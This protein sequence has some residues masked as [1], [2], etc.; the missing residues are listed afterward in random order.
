MRVGEGT[1]DRLAAYSALVTQ[2]SPR[3]DLVAPG[4]VVRF[5]QRHIEDCLRLLSLAEGCPPGAAADVGSGAGLPGLVLAIAQPEQLWRL[6][7]P[8]S[9]RAA[10][11]EE[12]VRELDLANVEVL[13]VT[14][15]QGAARA[16]LR[17]GHILA[18]ARALAPPEESLRL[19]RPLLAPGGTAAVFIGKNARIPSGAEEWLDG[20][21]IQSSVAEEA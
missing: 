16:D 21:V 12:V 4:D 15:Q 19:L 10:F 8:R 3:L 2:W 11:L 17:R 6:F 13:A 5:R 9:S 7:E 14:A 1:E 18:V 20:I